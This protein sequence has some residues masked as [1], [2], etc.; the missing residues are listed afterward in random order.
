MKIYRQE[1]NQE[2]LFDQKGKLM[3]IHN[4]TENVSELTH[5]YRVKLE[6]FE[7]LL[8]RIRKGEPTKKDAR[9]IKDL[10]LV[11]YDRKFRETI[12]NYPKTIWVCGKNAEKDKKTLKC[13]LRHHGK[14]RL[15]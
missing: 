8:A 3:F 12:K 9:K 14:T 11:H 4:M 13:L 5:N 15:Q 1:K 10:Y 7:N 2:G 6:S